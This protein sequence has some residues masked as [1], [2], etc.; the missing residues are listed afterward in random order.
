MPGVF[1]PY[2]LVD[3]LGT[4]NDQSSQ[5]VGSEIVNGLGY[6][7][8]VDET[9]TSADSAFTSVQLPPGWDQSVWGGFLWG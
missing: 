5:P 2:S 3:I 1:R 9:I 7:A 8:E 6:F 4:L